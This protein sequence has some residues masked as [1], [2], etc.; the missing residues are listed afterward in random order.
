MCSKAEIL[1]YRKQIGGT[2]NAFDLKLT[3]VYKNP[4]LK[5][6]GFNKPNPQYT[7]DVHSNVNVTDD[8]YINGERYLPTGT[9]LPFVGDTSP[10]QYW[11]LCQGQSLLIADY[12][13]LFAVISNRYGGNGVTTF[14]LPDLRGRVPVGAG[15]PDAG[16]TAFTNRTLGETGGAETHTLDITEIP[17]HRHSYINNTNDQNTDNAF[18]TETAADQ[19]DL[20]ATTGYA[21][22]V[23]TTSDVPGPTAPHN[24]MQPFVVLN[25]IIRI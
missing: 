7:L 11:F 24:I 14:R 4:N 3:H 21:G 1:L 19:A 5:N 15:D 20:S 22:G 2:L 10:G 6:F 23:G 9:V 18:A 8:Y 13:K 17:A 25:Y 16:G 12:P